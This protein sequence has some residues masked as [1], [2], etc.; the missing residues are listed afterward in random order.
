MYKTTPVDSAE[1][2]RQASDTFPGI[3]PEFVADRLDKSQPPIPSPKLALQI[4]P[5]RPAMIEEAC[6]AVWRRGGGV[7]FKTNAP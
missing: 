2:C 5:Y 3:F 1:C 7:G 6:G 4:D